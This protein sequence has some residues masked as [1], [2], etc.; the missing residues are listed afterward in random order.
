[1]DRTS[2]FGDALS[3]NGGVYNYGDNTATR[4]DNRSQ[5]WFA[6]KYKDPALAQL[7]YNNMLTYN[8]P[9]T[10]YDLSLIHI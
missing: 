4:S 7:R 3:G 2:Y 6:A 8:F 10:L 9:T 1:M 5:E